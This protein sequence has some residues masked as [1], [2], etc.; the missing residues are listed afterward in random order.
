[1]FYFLALLAFQQC[2]AMSSA[3]VETGFSLHNVIKRK[4]RRSLH[5]RMLDAHM[6][7]HSTAKLSGLYEKKWTVESGVDDTPAIPSV[8]SAMDVLE[9]HKTSDPKGALL[10]KSLHVQLS[11]RHDESWCKILEAELNESDAAAYDSK[12]S[13]SDQEELT[14]DN[15]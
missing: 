7:V 11:I 3:V 9:L 1:M 14:S 8:P 15:D 4:L 12:G 10:V 6:R 2:V 5:V 13:I